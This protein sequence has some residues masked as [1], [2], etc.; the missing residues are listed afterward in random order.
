MR[1]AH[2]GRDGVEKKNGDEQV[3]ADYSPGTEGAKKGNGC[4]KK[5]RKRLVDDNEIKRRKR[6]AVKAA[7]EAKEAS[8]LLAQD[9]ER[10]TREAK[11][12]WVEAQCLVMCKRWQGEAKIRFS[13]NTSLLEQCEGEWMTEYERK[14]PRY[15]E[16]QRTTFYL[17][18]MNELSSFDTLD[19]YLVKKAADEADV[20]QYGKVIDMSETLARFEHHE[21]KYES[22]VV[23]ED[24]DYHSVL[25]ATIA[26]QKRKMIETRA[27]YV[28]KRQKI[29]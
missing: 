2:Q 28:A 5:N 6:Q 13:S 9:I 14:A 26:A 8:H 1:F 10:R 21:A 7:K 4:C 27:K 18:K 23:C 22:L 25:D 11:E 17:E 29:E 24:S 19:N 16:E 15:V 12:E 20:K 3:I